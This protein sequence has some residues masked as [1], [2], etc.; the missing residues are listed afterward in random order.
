MTYSRKKYAGSLDA[1]I[2]ILCRDNP[3]K[4]GKKAHDRFG[5]Y[6]NGMTVRQYEKACEDAP[7]PQDALVDITWD[8]LHG[9]IRL[10]P[11][12]STV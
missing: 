6:R 7:R 2:E 10:L 9:F 8:E 5:L 3:K 11:P 1:V 12:G 4:L